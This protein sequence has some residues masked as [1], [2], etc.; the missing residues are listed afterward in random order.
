[1]R[2]KINRDLCPAQLAFCERCLGKFL[3]NPMAYERR[4]FE[5]VDYENGGTEKLIIE[6]HSGDHEVIFELSEEQRR[7]VAIEGWS[8]FTNFD[9][10]MYR[11]QNN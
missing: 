10:P 1:M 3:L 5:F 8:A 9:V 2:V 7:L 6:M 11:N 4:C